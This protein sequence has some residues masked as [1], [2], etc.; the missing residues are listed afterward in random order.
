MDVDPIGPDVD[1]LDQDSKQATLA[2]RGQAG[3]AVAEFSGSRHE[4]ALR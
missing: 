1:A 3:P 2:C 4:P